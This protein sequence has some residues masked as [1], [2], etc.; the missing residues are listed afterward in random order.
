MDVA[1]NFGRVS[2]PVGVLQQVRVAPPPGNAP[3][4]NGAPIG[5]GASD[6]GLGASDLGLG[7]LR[8]AYEDVAKSQAS[9]GALIEQ[10][11]AAL[12]NQRGPSLLGSISQELAKPNT[13]PGI[14]GMLEHISGGLGAYD[15]AK[16]AYDQSQADTALKYGLKQ[17]ELQGESAKT[18]GEQAINLGT[19][20]E[21]RNAVTHA[22]TEVNGQTV[23]TFF[24][25]NG[26]EVSQQIIGAPRNADETRHGILG[27]YDDKNI[28]RPY[29]EY[30]QPGHDKTSYL[31]AAL[32]KRED[33]YLGYINDFSGIKADT[34]ALVTMV[35]DKN[36]KL[37]AVSNWWNKTSSDLGFGGEEAANYNSFRSTLETMRN[38][39]LLLAKGVQTEGDAARAWEGLIGSI[40]SKE[41]VMRRLAEIA[42]MNERNAVKAAKLV[43]NQRVQRG[44]A[45]LDLADW[46]DIPS[47]LSVG[48]SKTP[49]AAAKEAPAAAKEAPAKGPPAPAPLPQSALDEANK[50][51]RNRRA[52][53]AQNTG[54]K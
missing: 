38:A 11:K 27:Y 41:V 28:W 19:L 30:A 44:L 9:Q 17:A 42:K 35:S 52:A 13:Q 49:P 6:L 45:P 26:K 25:R 37:N 53:E 33:E 31:P 7:A 8:S 54:E 46:T 10:A 48:R 22:D 12:R 16:A 21:K 43:Q 2:V 39:S 29:A 14:A 40:G 36:F 51:L 47:V 32:Q 50:I 18:R 4:D 24:D 3:A 23:R 15:A 5:L 34:E 20:E 1:S